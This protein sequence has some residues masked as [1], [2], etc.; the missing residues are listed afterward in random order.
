LT[1]RSFN[2]GF[3]ISAIDVIVLLVGIFAAADIGALI[4]WF[5]AAIAFVVGHF[6]LFCNVI[7]MA[8]PSEL[9]WAVVFIALTIST[10]I[11]G[12]PGWPI[13]FFASLIVTV[14]LAALELR[15]PEYHGVFWRRIN[16]GLPQWWEAN[17]SA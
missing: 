8:R 3:R 2:P 1:N 5:G 9:T 11:L 17:R 7:R 10:V 12:I 13:S 16:P 4:P 14:V 6:F 15:K